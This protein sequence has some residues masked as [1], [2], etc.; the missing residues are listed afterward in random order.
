MTVVR[1]LEIYGIHTM[2][3]IL[4]KYSPISSDFD[5]ELAGDFVGDTKFKNLD[6]FAG[7]EYAGDLFEDTQAGDIDNS[8]PEFSTTLHSEKI[9]KSQSRDC[10]V[11]LRLSADFFW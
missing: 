8:L 1:N 6:I 9:R 5:G 11:A 4:P 3:F 10:K 2:T 7:E